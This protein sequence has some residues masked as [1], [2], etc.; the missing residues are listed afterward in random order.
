MNRIF[1]TPKTDTKV[2]KPVNGHLDPKG[3]EVNE[4][5]YWLRR[6]AD[7][8]VTISEA[9]AASPAAD[10]TKAATGRAKS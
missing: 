7:G 1:V 2:R 4:E 6:A 3:E 8:D 5:G 9:P 10:L